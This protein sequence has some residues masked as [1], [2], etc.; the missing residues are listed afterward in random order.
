MWCVCVCKFVSVYTAVIY[1]SV[2]KGVGNEK[3]KIIII[4]DAYAMNGRLLSI[5]LIMKRKLVISFSKFHN[6]CTASS[7]ILIVTWKK[8]EVNPFFFAI[9][10]NHWML[11]FLL[12]NE[13]LFIIFFFFSFRLSISFFQQTGSTST[14]STFIRRN[15]TEAAHFRFY[16]GILIFK[17]HKIA[18][19]RAP[20]WRRSDFKIHNFMVLTV[21]T[22]CGF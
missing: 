16:F 6:K 14:A 19:L 7:I 21:K 12:P 10:S 13:F 17:V 1:C 9:T 22:R 3:K 18:L 2:L 8:T 20:F 4:Y 11:T 15:R 5:S